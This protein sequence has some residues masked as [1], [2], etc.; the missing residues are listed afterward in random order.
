MVTFFDEMKVLYDYQFGFRKEHSTSIALMLLI[1]RVSKALHEGEY[2]L[3]VFIDFSKAFDT[4]N[5]DILL[6]KLWHYGIKGFAHQWLTSYLSNRKQF[7]CFDGVNS[8]YDNITC[9]VPQG[10]SWGPYCF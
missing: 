6:S 5:H 7:V 10:Q 1:D 8:P 2:V 9:G 3:G 4:V